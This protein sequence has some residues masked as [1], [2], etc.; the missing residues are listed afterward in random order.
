M[1]SAA[2]WEKRALAVM[3][4]G[5]E[6]AEQ[7]IDRLNRAYNAAAKAIEGEISA[8]F[9]RY[10]TK[11]G[12]SYADALRDLAGKEYRDWR[13]TLEDYV[14]RINATGDGALLRELDALSARSRITRYQE[15]LTEI[16]VQ[17]AELAQKQQDAVSELLSGVYEDSYYRTAFDVQRGLGFGKTLSVL[18]M[19]T[20]AEAAAYPWSGASFSDRIWRNKDR[21][22]QVLGDTLTEGLIRGD[23]VQA[24]TEKLR[25]KVESSRYDAERL[26]RTETARVVESAGLQAYED[27]EI[28]EYEL[29]AALDERTY[30][31][32]G[33]LDGAQ[34]KLKDARTGLNLPPLHP[35]CRCTTIPVFVDLDESVS[36]R[37]AR[38]ENGGHILVPG[39][40]TY[41]Q[42]REKFVSRPEEMR[43][44]DF[45]RTVHAE[46]QSE[47]PLTLNAGVQNKHI[48]G[49]A[50]FDPSRSELT[51]D[52]EELIRL[53]AGK[54]EP[55]LSK[56]GIWNQ[57]ERFFHDSEIGIW[58]D[59]R[60]GISAPTNAGIFHYSKKKGI[61]IVPAKP[62][63]G[64]EK[65]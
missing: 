33:K 2:Y 28:E 14:E 22:V 46:I 21:L 7:V 47:Y 31:I 20:A 30:P 61:H 41:A 32:C 27:C 17:A 38:D 6:D 23:G 5:M 3:D 24:L 37:A 44:N 8:L 10:A 15:V 60:T 50:N 36:R 56:S 13:M 9:S 55:I 11:H 63:M 29:L 25:A 42:W 49:R 39:D 54:S 58:R 59:K 12:L 18:P 34:Y 53:Y 26:V 4:T 1:K 35:N 52:P 57:R 51:A 65:R 19:G 16:K 62:R 45:R 64:G 43:Y 48:R 40:M